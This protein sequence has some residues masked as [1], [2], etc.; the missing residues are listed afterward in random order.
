MVL[1]PTLLRHQ[2]FLACSPTLFLALIDQ[3]SLQSHLKAKRLLTRHTK[4][5]QKTNV[6]VALTTIGA[7]LGAASQASWIA[8]AYFLTSVRFTINR[9]ANHL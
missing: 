1:S 3:V 2:V 8:S 7:D 5:E 6:S 9:V 4:H